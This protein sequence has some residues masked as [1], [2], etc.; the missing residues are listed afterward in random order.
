M[1]AFGKNQS[2][3][4]FFVCQN[5]PMYKIFYFG[6]SFIWR[7]RSLISQMIKLKRN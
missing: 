6:N 4:D 7:S 1:I 3:Y 5:Y 2:F